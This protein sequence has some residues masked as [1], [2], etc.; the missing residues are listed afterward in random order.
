VKTEEMIFLH[1]R[2]APRIDFTPAG[3]PFADFT[4]K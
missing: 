2:F 4:V 1:L 3:A